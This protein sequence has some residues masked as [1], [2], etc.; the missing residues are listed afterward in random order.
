MEQHHEKGT[1]VDL[2]IKLAGALGGRFKSG[3]EWKFDRVE[4]MRLFIDC[5]QALGFLPCEDWL[6]MSVFVTKDALQVPTTKK[7]EDTQ[8]I[9]TAAFANKFRFPR[10]SDA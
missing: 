7:G 3:D 6:L 4:N 1:L 5:C 9:N 2:I 10:H 8:V